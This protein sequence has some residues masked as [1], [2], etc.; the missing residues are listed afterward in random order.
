MPEEPGVHHLRQ[1][2][3]RQG[4]RISCVFLIMGKEAL[5]VLSISFLPEEQQDCGVGFIL[6]FPLENLPEV[7]E[8]GKGQ[9]IE[10]S[11][12]NNP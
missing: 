6:S 11:L 12:P 4:R 8:M 3:G 1:G 10:Y 2:S 7:S 5:Q 9:D